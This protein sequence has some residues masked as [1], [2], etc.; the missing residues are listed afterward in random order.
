MSTRGNAVARV[1]VVSSQAL[2]AEL[3]CQEL[4]LRQDLASVGF[5]GTINEAAVLCASVGPDVVVVDCA[6]PDGDGLDAAERIL[7]SALLAR[8]ILLTTGPAQEILSRATETG[9]SGVLPMNGSLEGLM[10]AIRHARPGA[11]TVHPS[12][13]VP[14]VVPVAASEAPALTRREM[15]VLVLLAEGCDVRT[16]ARNLNITLNTCRGYVK[17]ILSKLDSRTQL[18]AVASARKLQL[19]A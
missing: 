19:L 1:A 18:Q 2:F 11:M 9:I 4:T 5:A 16:T 10:E 17:S 12:L 6:L 13:L 15:Q 14:A 3:L 8:I 7:A